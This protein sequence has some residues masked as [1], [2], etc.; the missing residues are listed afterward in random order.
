MLFA[1]SYAEATSDIACWVID[2][3]APPKLFGPVKVSM[4]KARPLLGYMQATRSNLGQCLLHCARQ[5]R[6]WGDHRATIPFGARL[7]V[8]RRNGRRLIFSTSAITSNST[9]DQSHAFPSVPP[10]ALPPNTHTETPVHNVRSVRQ[11][12]DGG[13]PGH[14]GQ[15]QGPRAEHH[16]GVYGRRL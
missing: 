16:G 2:G 5:G 6:Y 7:V 15:G 11:P 4:V 14:Q 8:N 12:A 13:C 1:Y 3:G 10:T 9:T